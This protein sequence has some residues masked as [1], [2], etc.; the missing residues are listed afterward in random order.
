MRKG[1]YLGSTIIP[2]YLAYVAICHD[3]MLWAFVA[4]CCACVLLYKG[5]VC[6]PEQYDN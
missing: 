2:L 3:K 5:G 4:L 6:D 1:I